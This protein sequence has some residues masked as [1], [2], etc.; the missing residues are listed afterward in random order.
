VIKINLLGVE[1][2]K[3]KK[4][5]AFQVGQKLTLGCSLILIVTAVLIGWRYWAVTKESAR[6]DQ[7]IEK[8]QKETVRLH[9]IIT[10]VQQFEQRKAQLQQRVTLIEQLRKE[11]TGPVHILD[12]VS[13]ALPSMMWLTDL[14]ETAT[15]NEIL[16]EGR[17]LNDTIIADF[18]ANLEGSGYF[19]RSIDIVSVASEVAPV[20]PGQIVKFNLRATFRQPGS[21]AKAPAPAASALPKKTADN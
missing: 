14:K 5:V 21:D 8:A 15:A 10:Q 11:Q 13:R 19:E 1:Q 6:L 16:I 18:V 9:S 2:R 12:Q 4:K 3:V 17:C 7:E 20:P